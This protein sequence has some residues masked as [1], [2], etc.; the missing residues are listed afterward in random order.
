MRPFLNVS[1]RA[2]LM[3]MTA[4]SASTKA[5]RGRAGSGAGTCRAG[6][7]SAPRR[8]RAARRG[9]PGR[10]SAAAAADRGRRG[11]LELR[12]ARALRE[13]ARDDDEVGAGGRDGRAQRLEQPRIDAAE[14]QVGEMD[15]GAHRCRLRARALA[16]PPA[17]SPQARRPDTIVQRRRHHRHLAVGSA[18]GAG[19]AT[20]ISSPASRRSRAP[21]DA[22]EGAQGHDADASGR[23]L[24]DVEAARPRAGRAASEAPSRTRCCR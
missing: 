14:V 11:L 8:G 5:A 7:G 1:E 2:V 20:T 12:A 15:E 18:S 9:C 3:P 22:A 17:A 16:R 10:R 19:A 23:A 24:R 6:S 13:V 4:I 21:G